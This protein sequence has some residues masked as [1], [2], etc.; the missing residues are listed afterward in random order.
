MCA[1][2]GIGNLNFT[3]SIGGTEKNDLLICYDPNLM[4]QIK[5]PLPNGEGVFFLLFI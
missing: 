2:F 1:F 5:H 3:S 4:K